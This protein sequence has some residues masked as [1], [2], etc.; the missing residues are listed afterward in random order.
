VTLTFG[1]SARGAGWA[2]FHTTAI[3]SGLLRMA[4]LIALQPDINI[5]LHIV[6]PDE[7]HDR[8][9]SEIKRPIFSSLEKAPLYGPMLDDDRLDPFARVRAACDGVL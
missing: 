5:R 7:K 6:A 8:V 4:D 3:Y 1:G 9:M 2:R